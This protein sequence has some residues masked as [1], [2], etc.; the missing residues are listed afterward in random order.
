MEFL[1]I[2]FNM[3]MLIF[4]A[5]K[6]ILLILLL[7]LSILY[8]FKQKKHPVKLYICIIFLISFALISIIL[9]NH[10]TIILAGIRWMLPLFLSLFLYNLVDFEFVK[11]VSNILFC[12]LI[13]NIILQICEMFF[14]P[15]FWGHNFLGLSGRLPGFFVHPSSSGTF[16]AFCCFFTAYFFTGKKRKLG[17]ALSALGIFLSMSST[18]IMLVAILIAI[19]FY[20]KSKLKPLI[21]ILIPLMILAVVVNLD[22]LT[23]RGEGD[24]EL[25]GTTRLLILKDF[26]DS[27][28][29][30]STHFG[31][32]TNS[33]VNLLEDSTNSDKAFIVD[34]LY[35]SVLVNL[36]S[37]FFCLFI[38]F[39][40]YLITRAFEI[41]NNDLSFISFV[42]ICVVA[43]IP[44]ITAELFPISLLIT[45]LIAFYTKKYNLYY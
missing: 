14:M 45:I 22:T 7:F 17:I 4:K 10:F 6:D 13:L 42:I 43:G 26:V 33:A 24:S 1:E 20:F 30:I 29:I 15:P 5:P 21:I 28:E 40:I 35:T 44:V 32:G 25:S 3:P 34:S 11:K 23:G 16:S 37:V 19:P 27:S 8:F 18:S 41:G 12:L 39:N 31:V 9:S 38:F 36:G 2:S